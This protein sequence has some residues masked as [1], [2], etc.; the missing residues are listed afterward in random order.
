MQV[1][2]NILTLLRV[3]NFKLYSDLVRDKGNASLS[4]ANE[5]VYVIPD[6][7]NGGFNDV[8]GSS[9]T[10]AVDTVVSRV[11]YSQMTPTDRNYQSSLSLT[12]RTSPETLRA[13]TWN[14][15]FYALV[16]LTNT[17]VYFAAKVGL[18]QLQEHFYWQSRQLQRA[19]RKYIFKLSSIRI[20]RN[21]SSLI[22][23][24]SWK[25]IAFALS[26]FIVLLQR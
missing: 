14:L 15:K 18:L 17:A 26:K 8:S 11:C 25:W 24:E 20:F 4:L 13:R 21:I 10:R 6:I 1:C 2:V 7:R 9:T 19:R 16:K 23:I 12:A 5:Y 3:H 22:F